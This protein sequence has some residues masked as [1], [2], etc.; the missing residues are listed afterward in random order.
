MT[1]DLVRANEYDNPEDDTPEE[2]ADRIALSRFKRAVNSARTADEFTAAAQRLDDDLMKSR[3]LTKTMTT[4]PR[5]AQ[6]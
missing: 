3:T 4:A 2:R 6:P 5:E 1:R